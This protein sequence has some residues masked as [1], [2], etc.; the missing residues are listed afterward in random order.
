[1]SETITLNPVCRTCQTTQ[2]IV[3]SESG[4]EAW[5]NGECIQNVMPELTADE[6]ELLISGICGTCFD[7]MFLEEEAVFEDDDDEWDD[8]EYV[9]DLRPF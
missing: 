6:R 8:D 3:V 5:N 2:M 7:E 9:D 1:M 4:Y